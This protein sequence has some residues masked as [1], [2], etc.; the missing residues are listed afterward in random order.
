MKRAACTGIPGIL[1]SETC[2]LVSPHLCLCLSVPLAIQLQILQ[3]QDLGCMILSNSLRPH[4][5]PYK[6]DL[7]SV[8]L[9]SLIPRSWTCT[10]FSYILQ[11]G[12]DDSK[13]YRRVRGRLMTP[14]AAFDHFDFLDLVG[15]FVKGITEQGNQSQ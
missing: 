14:R 7:N 15:K 2:K 12:A 3:G 9:G 4:T 6:S 11:V 5:A 1:V 10:L 8:M 13:P